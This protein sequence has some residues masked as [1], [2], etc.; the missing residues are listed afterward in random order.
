M[1]GAEWMLP[2]GVLDDARS[3]LTE[4]ISNAVKH[5]AW[6]R[7]PKQAREIGVTLS[8][9]AGILR[10]E[11]ADP[12]PTLP[13]LGQV[14][15]IVDIEDF[16]SAIGLGGYGLVAVVAELSVRHGAHPVDGGKVVW[17]DLEARPIGADR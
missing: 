5:A 15:R 4:L 14:P 10:I 13:T 16:D 7:V 1:L 9:A 8:L 12:D 6:H 17:A 11:V 3:V 2:T